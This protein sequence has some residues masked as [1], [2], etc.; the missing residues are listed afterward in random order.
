MLGCATAPGETSDI[1]AS[2]TVLRDSGIADANLPD[3][4]PPDAQSLPC[5]GGTI[6]VVDPGTG[7]CYMYF[8]AGANWTSAQANCVALGGGAHLVTIMDSG[9]NSFVRNLAGGDF[10]IGASDVDV[11]GTF[12]WV[13]GEAFAFDAWNGGEPNNSNGNEDCAHMRS[14]PTWNDSI[15]GSSQPYM[16]ER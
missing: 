8:Q 11:E 1:D 10:W 9:E 5:E 12:V 14:N 3:A 2:Q 16:C 7:R 4:A 15:C 6:N 13:T